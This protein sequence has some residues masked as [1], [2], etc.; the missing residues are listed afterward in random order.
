MIAHFFDLDILINTDSGVWIVSKTQPKEPLIR[1]SQSEFNLI[2]KGI[3]KKFNTPVVMSGEKYWFPENLMNTLKIR[4]KK[5]NCDITNLSFSMQEY[6]NPEIIENLDYEIL[7]HN[8]IHLKNSNDDIYIICSKSTKDSY[9][10]IIKKLEE[11]MFEIGLKPKDYY[12]IS[13]TFYNKN[14]DDISHKKV[15]LLLQHLVGFKTSINKFTDESITK[16]DK[17]MFYDN[18]A[19]VLKLATNVNSLLDIIVSNTD[20]SLSTNI[21]NNL[22]TSPPYLVVNQITSNKIEPF[23]TKII[24]L[25]LNNFIKTFE[26]FKIRY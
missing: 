19:S 12:F 23:Y 20:D 2:R 18:D 15:R 8:F 13:E 24:E 7:I 10:P 21:K 6:M 1:I 9:Q 4:C 5:N 26:S 17:V 11:K 25:K 22:K 14:S 16:Y 3:Y